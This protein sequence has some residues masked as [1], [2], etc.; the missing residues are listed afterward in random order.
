V[1]KRPTPAWVKK[2]RVYAWCAVGWAVAAVAGWIWVA[3]AAWVETPRDGAG[4]GAV[5]AT[6]L[7]FAVAWI[8]AKVR[9]FAR[10]A[11]RALR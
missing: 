2:L 11:K 1:R 3:M 9:R 6:G 7:A 8:R 10:K 4:T 5:L